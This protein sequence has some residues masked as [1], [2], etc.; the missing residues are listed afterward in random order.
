[1]RVRLLDAS[2]NRGHQQNFVAFLEG[3][4]LSAQE[5]YVFFVHVDVEKAADLALVIAQVRLEFRELLV[6]HREQLAHI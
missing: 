6:E 1:M 4:R 2:R 3:I 5:A